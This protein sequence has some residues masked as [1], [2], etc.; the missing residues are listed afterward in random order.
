M[1]HDSSSSTICAVTYLHVLHTVYRDTTQKAV[2]IDAI[3]PLNLPLGSCATKQFNQKKKKK[4]AIVAV[5]LPIW[6]NRD[7]SSAPRY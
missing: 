1:G 6:N 5:T 3:T 7:S 2:F 4:V